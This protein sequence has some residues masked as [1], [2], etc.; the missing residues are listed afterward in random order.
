MAGG[1]LGGTGQIRSALS[2]KLK[3]TK[4]KIT[5][6]ATQIYSDFSAERLKW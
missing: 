3:G 5:C 1:T 6:R 2:L 4:Q